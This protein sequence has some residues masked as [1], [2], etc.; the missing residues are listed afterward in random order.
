MSVECR[1]QVFGERML[2]RVF[3][4]KDEDVLYNELVCLI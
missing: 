3:V 4:L 1:L 2:R